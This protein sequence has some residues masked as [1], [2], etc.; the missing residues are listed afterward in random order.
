MPPTLTRRDGQPLM[1]KLTRAE[2]ARVE[3]LA[4]S[5]DLTMSDVARQALRYGM[6]AWTQAGP[7]LTRA[8]GPEAAE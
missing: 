2:R 8:G 1:V 3:Q 6:D 4:K 5:T 7:P